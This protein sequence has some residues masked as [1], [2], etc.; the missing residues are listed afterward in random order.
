MGLPISKYGSVASMSL[1][2]FCRI[3][4]FEKSHGTPLSSQVVMS[5]AAPASMPILGKAVAAFGTVRGL[6]ATSKGPKSRENLR[7][8][9]VFH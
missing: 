8:T 3:S 2:A 4:S 9:D 5:K 6:P 1:S 7:K